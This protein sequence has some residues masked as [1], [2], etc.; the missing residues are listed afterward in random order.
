MYWRRELVTT[1]WPIGVR[2]AVCLRQ[3]HTD[4]AHGDVAHSDVTHSDVAHSDV[5]HT[6]GNDHGDISDKG[7]SDFPV[8]ND[9]PHSDVAHSDVAHGDVAHSD[10]ALSVISAMPGRSRVL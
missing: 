6:D 8:H 3:D 4:V 10:I 9:T 5:A 2:G 1:S 7:H